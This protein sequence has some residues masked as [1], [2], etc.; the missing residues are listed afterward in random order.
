MARKMMMLITAC[1]LIAFTAIPC[2]AQ[3]LKDGVV[4][5]PCI[6]APECDDLLKDCVSDEC[7]CSCTGECTPGSC[8]SGFPACHPQYMCICIKTAEGLGVCVNVIPCPLVDEC[9]TS[10]DCSQGEVCFLGVDSCCDYSFC[11]PPTC[12][13]IPNGLDVTG[14]TLGTK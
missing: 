7:I 3:E 13:D 14:P 10:S 12:T 11:L 6:C 1:L 2:F 9:S 8:A 4:A 5:C